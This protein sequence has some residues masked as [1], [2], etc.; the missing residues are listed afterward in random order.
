MKK[1]VL[2][3]V[4]I[5]HVDHGK[6]TL[7][8]RLLF[9]TNSLP[10]EK[11]AEI[12]KISKNLGKNMELAYL[13][14]QF[15]EEREQNL[16]IDTTQLFFK[17]HKRNYIIIDAPGHV[18]FIKNM[19][20]GASLAQAAL[21]IVDAKEGIMGGTRR[22]AYLIRLLGLSSI[23]VAFNKMDLIDYKKD[24]FDKI[25]T[26]I[27]NFLEE[28]GIKPLFSIPISAKNG[29]NISKK[30]QKI[31]W[32]KG[33]TLIEAIDSFRLDKKIMNEPLRFPVQDTYKI[34][35]EKIIVGRISS[36]LIK[37]D[38]KVTLF[39]SF[40]DAKIKTIQVFGKHRRSAEKGESIGV[41]LKNALSVRRGN[42]IF[43]KDD[44]LM[45]TERFKANIFWM[46][47]NPLEI[48][49]LI[50]LRCATQ[51]VKCIVEK[52]EKRIDSST[53]ETLET[54]AGSL[55]QNEIG[56]LT[57][58]TKSPLIVERFDIIEE[59]GR[60]ILERENSTCAGGIITDKL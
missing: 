8:G 56:T 42:L 24:R 51:E 11:I 49:K 54:N 26:E 38:Y 5:G 2:K 12:K 60:F 48:N 25:K 4:L 35:N 7:I 16:T 55:K 37:Q 14:D 3:I 58:K 27:L 1:D 46:S 39:P 17:T 59:L 19:I 41:T 34:G 6:S 36:G 43:K 57:L 50:T 32:H 10:K 20:T 47:N 30:S 9:E 29:I 45:P 22:H 18:E 44:S 21:L 31:G 33:P 13:A 53:L 52:I 23:I 15:K 28:L 40:K